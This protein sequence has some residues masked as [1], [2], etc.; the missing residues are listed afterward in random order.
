M[1]EMFQNESTGENVEGITIIVDGALKQFLEIIKSQK[2]EYKDNVS[3]VQD[4]L[5]K[6]LEEIRKTI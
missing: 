2:S 3:I 4:A 1:T 5:M 6:G